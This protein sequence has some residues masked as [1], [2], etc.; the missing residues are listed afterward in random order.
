MSNMQTL[1]LIGT[2]IAA[3]VVLGILYLAYVGIT[4]L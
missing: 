3:T 4:C 1:L 2:A